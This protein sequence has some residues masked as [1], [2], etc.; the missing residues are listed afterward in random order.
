[1]QSAPNGCENTPPPASLDRHGAIATLQVDGAVRLAAVRIAIATY[2]ALRGELSERNAQRATRG[3]APAIATALLRDQRART[4]KSHLVRSRNLGTCHVHRALGVGG[5]MLSAAGSQC[6]WC[7]KKIGLRL[8]WM[9]RAV[10]NRWWMSSVTRGRTTRMARK[11]KRWP[12]QPLRP[13]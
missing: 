5:V 1:M 6:T 13:P 7:N 3:A 11:K 2:A 12:Q 4:C 9:Q 10:C 8:R